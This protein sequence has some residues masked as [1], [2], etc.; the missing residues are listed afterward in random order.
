MKQTP[1][2][3]RSESDR[4][5]WWGGAVLNAAAPADDPHLPELHR[6]NPT[7]HQQQYTLPD[8]QYKHVRLQGTTHADGVPAP[9]SSTQ[10]PLTAPA[11]AAAL[12]LNE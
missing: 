11:P 10:L 8:K 5:G 7:Q 3:S 4:S 1:D 9:P 6:T 12:S 2:G